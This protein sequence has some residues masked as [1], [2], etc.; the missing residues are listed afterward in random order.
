M[1]GRR[2][3][4]APQSKVVRCFLRL[5]ANDEEFAN[6]LRWVQ[7]AHEGEWKGHAFGEFEFTPA[8]FRQMVQNFHR[9][10]SYK[11]G[12]QDAPVQRI[13][14][15]D[16]DVIQYDWRHA[17]TAPPGKTPIEMQ[18]AQA[19]ACDL[20]TDVGEDGRACLWALT[21]YLEPMATFVREGK[22]HWTSV[23]ADAH[24]IDPVSGEDWGW[25]IEAIAFTNDPFL[26]GM[27]VAASRT[28]TLSFWRG[29]D[30]YDPP[31]TAH[32]ALEALRGLFEL[33]ATAD[34]GAVLAELGKLRVWAT[35]GGA[36]VGVEVDELVGCIKQL[37]NLPLL[38][39]PEDVF[40][41]T[42]QLLAALA[43]E[44]PPA[45]ER[46]PLERSPVS[47][48]DSRTQ[49]GR[50]TNAM[51][52]H[53]AKLLA[54]L[55]AAGFSLGRASTDEDAVEA[56]LEWSSKT[57]VTLD[58][59][60]GATQGLQ[61]V[62]QAL[63]V[64]DVDGATKKIAEMFKSVDMLEKAMPELKALRDTQEKSEEDQAEKDVGDA[65]KAHRMPEAARPALLAMR[66]GGL[67]RNGQPLTP[68]Q[69]KAFLA[70]RAA[71]RQRFQAA[72]AVSEKAAGLLGNAYPN[73]AA[74]AQPGAVR[75]EM[76]RTS[77]GADTEVLEAEGINGERVVDISGHPGRNRFE[78]A[79]SYVDANDP[80][81]KSYTRQ[82]KFH[83]ARRLL[84]SPNVNA[85]D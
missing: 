64:E 20:R 29:Y 19:W 33:P 53:L 23:T 15:G 11:A 35:Q 57:K 58:A 12:A 73:P 30:P 75:V 45:S 1:P 47:E 41:A 46:S 78:R 59:S 31:K 67:T 26:Q 50:T 74:G 27:K 28:G 80:K 77:P 66:T 60:G 16:F 34:F 71:A 4:I 36:P 55:A 76:R 8:D 24:Y 39:S 79:L 68:E 48:D 83:A 10:P 61:A 13:L 42:D 51:N 82:Q 69:S 18:V 25:Y 70:G 32:D 40:A 52:P 84:Q 49:N 56:I 3:K 43:A 72:Y 7:V 14:A 17:S 63:G 38:A 62:L 2:R 37:L 5:Q 85:G 22:V 54:K 81:A 65:M 6:G 9:H 44:E 21:R